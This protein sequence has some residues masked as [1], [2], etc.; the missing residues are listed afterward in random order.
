VVIDS[1]GFGY[2]IGIDFVTNRV[3]RE[4]ATELAYSILKRFV[5]NS[6]CRL[7]KSFRCDRI[8][9]PIYSMRYEHILLSLDGPYSNVMKI[10]PPLKFNRED[11]ELLLDTLDRILSKHKH[12]SNSKI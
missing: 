5:L 12:Q 4:P 7:Y 3:T 11:A 8:F 6:F 2:F 9:N 1:R 10:K